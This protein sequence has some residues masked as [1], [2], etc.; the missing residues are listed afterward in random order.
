MLANP[1]ART[2]ILL[3]F[4]LISS[5]ASGMFSNLTEL[6]DENTQEEVTGRSL[7]QL[8]W[9]WAVKDQNAGQ[10]ISKALHVDSSDGDIFVAGV[11]SG[12]TIV[13]GSDVLLNRGGFDIFLGKLDYQGNW[14]WGTSIGGPGDDQI[15]DMIVDS[16]EVITLVGAFNSSVFTAGN[17]S[18]NNGGGYDGFIVNHLNSSGGWMNLD[19]ITGSG[20]ENITGVDV[21]SS[22]GL[23]VSG[24]FDGPSAQLAQVNLTS[25]GGADMFFATVSNTGNWGWVRQYG[26]TGDEKANDIVW[27]PSNKFVA[28]GEFNSSSLQ[29]DSSTVSHGG[30]QGLD[31]FVIRSNMNAVEWV[32]K[33]IYI[34]GDRATHVTIDG[35]G[36]TFVGGQ[37]EIGN[38]MTWG[39]VQASCYNGMKGFYVTKI[40]S[41]GS[42][43]WAQNYCSRYSSNYYQSSLTSLNSTGSVLIVG[44]ETNANIISEGSTSWSNCG[45]HNYRNTA[46]FKLVASS[47][48]VDTCTSI[49]DTTVGGAVWQSAPINKM[50]LAMERHGDYDNTNG[51]QAD[52]DTDTSAVL[53]SN[54]SDNGNS[55]QWQKSVGATDHDSIFAI[56]YSN[57]SGIIT[58]AGIMQSNS[59][60]LGSHVLSMGDNPKGEGAAFFIAQI[61]SNGNWI[62]GEVAPFDMNGLSDNYPKWYLGGDMAVAANGTVYLLGLY[63]QSIYF[64][65]SNYSLN[66]YYTNQ[67]FLASWNAT[68]GWLHAENLPLNDNEEAKIAL[69]GNGTLYLVGKCQYN[70]YMNLQSYSS[71]GCIAKRSVGWDWI[72]HGGGSCEIDAVAANTNGAYFSGKF[73]CSF[74]GTSSSSASFNY[75]GLIHVNTAGKYQADW[76]IQ[77]TTSDRFNPKAISLDSNNDVYIGGHFRD[78]VNFD[79]NTGIQSGGQEDGFLVKAA[80][81]GTWSWAISLGGTGYDG[82]LDI[83]TLE[84]DTIGVVGMKTGTISVGL[85]T[86]ASNGRA[87]VAVANAQGGWI[88]A[89]QMNNAGQSPEHSY[90]RAI[91]SSSNNT[92]SVAGEIIESTTVGLTTIN[93]PG[94]VDIFVAKMSADS[95]GDQITDNLDNC[96]SI[97]NNAQ[98]DLD[99]DTQGDLCDSDDDGDGIPDTS[100]SCY[101]GEVGWLSNN[102]TDHDS[103][104]CR[105]AMEDLDDDNDGIEDSLDSCS[106]GLTGWLSDSINDHDSDGCQD[107]AEDS[108]D[109]SDTVLDIVDSC[110]TGELDWISSSDTDIDS[111]GCRDATEDLDDDDD[112]VLDLDD[113]CSHGALGWN[114]NSS[115]DNDGDGCRDIDEDSNDDDDDFTDQDDYCPDGVVRWSSGVITDYDGDGCRD[116]DEDLDDDGDGV[117]DVDDQCPRSPLGWRTNPSVDFDADGCHD[118]NEDWD[119]DGDGISDL[120]DLCQITS[121]GQTV[122]ASGCAENDIRTVGSVGETGNE[123]TIVNE[124]HYH[125][126]TTWVNNT[127]VN[128]TDE[129]YNQ[130]YTNNSYTNETWENQTFIDNEYQN[131]SAVYN[132]NYT[133]NTQSDSDEEDSEPIQ[134]ETKGFVKQEWMIA[135]F[136]ILSLISIL[137]FIMYRKVKDTDW[138][139][140]QSEDDLFEISDDIS[141]DESVVEEDTVLNDEEPIATEEVEENQVVEEQIEGP[142]IDAEGTKD[143]SGYEWLE[144]PE[145]SGSNYYRTGQEEWKLWTE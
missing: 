34:Q 33:P 46:L 84:N 24:W 118:F 67:Y 47:G 105:D 113:V 116:I 21:N 136:V 72:H 115:T 127:F 128:N 99:S 61:D 73:G 142:P 92:L 93:T 38:T 48:Q 22:G 32:R 102:T 87:F 29:F 65:G 80:S 112:G 11:F 9:E 44:S 91:T 143:E 8:G 41:A 114:S 85:N 42:V 26:S 95:D 123:T 96:P 10:T 120:I 60:R 94:S 117:P 36:N 76:G 69:D 121:S 88:W 100:D 4:L 56:D 31:S 55:L 43:G 39:A 139:D 6:Q 19:S 79:S 63:D 20:N 40:S 23:I 75:G 18:V 52:I 49:M 50:I 7:N 30:G 101:Q 119:D 144:W 37:Y 141:V 74:T 108:D 71:G 51:I 82:V 81:N 126:N 70:T 15:Q 97:F 140:D 133:N 28:V 53:I 98:S 3:V 12:G 135:G 14:I 2:S 68:N 145:E 131:N 104:G 130:S 106:I 89:S 54:M 62:G 5:L 134:D 137:I 109:D 1:T 78:S 129:Y 13:L 59:L 107:S 86:L 77:S 125:N 35:I 124:N 25:N 64:D 90:A 27:S 132:Q 138:N 58:V 103:D 83:D 66:E 122:D 45:D 17:H 16:N 110:P 57:S 111:D